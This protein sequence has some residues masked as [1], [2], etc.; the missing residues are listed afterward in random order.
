MPTKSSRF[1]VSDTDAGSRLDRFVAVRAGV[2]RRRARELCENGRVTLDGRRARAS[3][4]VAA[5][6]NVELELPTEH[7]EPDS[8]TPL[9]VRL[10]TPSLVVVHKPAGQP[11]APLRPGELGTLANAL[12]ARYPETAE[13]GRKPRE[14]GLLHRLDTQTSGLVVACRTQGALQRLRAALEAGELEKRYFAVTAASDLPD[15]GELDAALAPDP[16]RRGRVRAVDDEASGYARS[17]LTR[18][19]VLERKGA[20]VLVELRMN[21]GFRHQVRAHLASIGAPLVGDALYGGRSWPEHPER[22]ALHAS[23]VAWA[24]DGTLEGFEV[25]ADMPADM[26]ELFGR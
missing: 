11:S 21:R 2:G 12:V 24:G 26:R 18:Y 15:E 8:L 20:L 7:A 23:Y 6:A 13:V 9:D 4:T 3:E 22:H 16:R 14:P 1:V 25:E 5:G 17:S 10:E 19:R